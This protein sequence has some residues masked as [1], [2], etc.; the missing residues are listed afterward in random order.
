MNSEQNTEFLNVKKLVVHQV[1]PEDLK[2]LNKVRG[3]KI[4]VRHVLH[5][6]SKSLLNNQLVVPV[7]IPQGTHDVFA[8]TSGR[9]V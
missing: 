2:R 1:S 3:V 7:S 6:L 9:A 8:E 5:V 4:K